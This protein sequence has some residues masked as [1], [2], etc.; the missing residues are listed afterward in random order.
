MRRNEFAKSLT[1]GEDK[2]VDCDGGGVTID[3]L[4]SGDGLSNS[5]CIAFGGDCSTTR[6]T[7]VRPGSDDTVF[8]LDPVPG[9]GVQNP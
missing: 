2:G 4:L 3:K 6:G 1:A 9:G 7:L 5:D 8:H